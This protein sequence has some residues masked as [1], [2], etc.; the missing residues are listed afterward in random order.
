MVYDCSLDGDGLCY[1]RLRLNGLPQLQVWSLR[2][3]AAPRPAS[4][5]DRYPYDT[6]ILFDMLGQVHN[7]FLTKFGRDGGNGRGGFSDG[8]KW[9]W[10]KTIA[11]VY[12][13]ANG[14]DC[15]RTNAY[16]STAQIEFC[17]GAVVTDVVGHEFAHGLTLFRFDNEGTLVPMTYQGESGALQENVSDIIGERSNTT[18]MGKPIGFWASTLPYGPS[19]NLAD[20]ALGRQGDRTRIATTTPS[21]TAARTTTAACTTTPTCRTKRLT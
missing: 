9:G 21:S 14:V 11:L 8:V 12:I 7:Y 10:D 20:P 2:A 19:R 4:D 15:S 18:S 3:I 16:A 6:D 17:Q 13:E 1:I 5:Q